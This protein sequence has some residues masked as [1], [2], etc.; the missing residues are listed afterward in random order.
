MTEHRRTLTEEAV[1]L[2]RRSLSQAK[3]WRRY[4]TRQ[5]L[6]AFRHPFN[7]C[8]LAAGDVL[9]CSR[10]RETKATVRLKWCGRRRC[11]KLQRK[12]AAG[13]LAQAKARNLQNTLEDVQEQT[14][15]AFEAIAGDLKQADREKTWAAVEPKLQPAEQRLAKAL[16]DQTMTEQDLRNLEADLNRQMVDAVNHDAQR[17]CRAGRSRCIPGRG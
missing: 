8:P 11:R 17:G 4:F 10:I 14:R 12:A 5:R 6:A 2:P 9:G 16:G 7:R 15:K 1:Q 3:G 13:A